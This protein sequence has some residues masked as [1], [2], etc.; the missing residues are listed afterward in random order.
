MT[1]NHP[2]AVQMRNKLKLHNYLK[3]ICA[4]CSDTYLNKSLGILTR[5]RLE[6]ACDARL[7]GNRVLIGL[8]KSIPVR[9]LINANGRNSLVYFRLRQQGVAQIGDLNPAN[10]DSME[11]FLN[12]RRLTYR[13]LAGTLRTR[14]WRR[15]TENDKLT[16]PG[17]GS[18]HDIR[19]LSA[20]EIRGLIFTK[21]PLCLFKS[22]VILNP[23]SSINYFNKISKLTSVAHKNILLRALH[24]DIYT[25]ERLFRFGMRD[26]PQCSRCESIDTL[27]HRLNECSRVV[28]MVN[29]LALKTAVLGNRVD[30]LS[31][32]IR[33]RLMAT[34]ND[35][36]VTTLTLHA[37]VT[38]IVCGTSEL[39]NPVVV[40]D[41]TIKM[42]IKKERNTE[43]KNQLTALL[44]N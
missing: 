41:R 26:N 15:P 29:I 30:R 12:D 32:E 43:I 13:L 22:G 11:R 39:T 27:E 3:P 9:E 44:H 2:L 5:V 34:Y 17:N 16:I 33:E 19:T 40:L 10:L 37:E 24:G 23:T 18:L 42:L 31:S 1:S 20:K 14:D 28:D 7:E 8:L 35:V 25:N 6:G 36:D 4:T 21:D 38:K